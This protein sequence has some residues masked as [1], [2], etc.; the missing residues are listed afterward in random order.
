MKTWIVITFSLFSLICDT[1]SHPEAVQV[2]MRL[3]MAN[4]D[5]FNGKSISTT[6][7]YV[8]EHHGAYLASN[9]KRADGELGIHLDFRHTFLSSERLKRVQYGHVRVLGTF[10]YRNRQMRI[11]KD[12]TIGTVAAGFG[13]MNVY[14]KQITNI[15]VFENVPAPKR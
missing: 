1:R 8:S 3:L 11:S 14:D 2:T 5:Q 6:G 7:Y 12:G 9:P 4:P 10:E 13:W 15:I